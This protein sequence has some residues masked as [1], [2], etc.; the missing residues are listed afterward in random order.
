MVQT[1]VF[2]TVLGGIASFV[3]GAISW[4]ALP[5]HH[6]T[7]KTFR[8]EDAVGRVL[9]ENAG[10][11]AVYGLPA[12]PVTRG[13]SK[14]EVAATETSVRAKLEAGPLALVVFQRQG[15]ESIKSRMLRAV[16]IGM[17]GSLLFQILL[18]RL[19]PGT[20]YLVRATLVGIGALAGAIVCRLPDWNWHGFSPQYTV[21]A[22]A[23]VTIGWFLVGLVLA[24]FVR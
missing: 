6:A 24:A 14:A 11:D 19:A 5:W 1:L 23:D 16:L 7:F 12:P 9:L 8:D 18:L 10:P 21:V 3:W 15:Y 4:M 17:L 22:I 20:P 13:M 2:G